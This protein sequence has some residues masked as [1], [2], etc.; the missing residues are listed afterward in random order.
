MADKIKGL[1]AGAD[2]YVTKP[3]NPLKVMAR[4]IITSVRTKMQVTPDQPDI[5]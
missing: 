3:F 2:D 4:K 1:V 5:L